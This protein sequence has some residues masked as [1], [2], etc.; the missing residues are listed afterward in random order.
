[1]KKLSL[2]LLLTLCCT[3]VANAATAVTLNY[4]GGTSSAPAT[5]EALFQ[6]LKTQFDMFYG[7]SNESA[8]IDEF[9]ANEANLAK[10]D[11]GRIILVEANTKTSIDGPWLW[12]ASYLRDA[13]ASGVG[14]K[15]NAQWWYTI[16]A[17]L[18]CKPKHNGTDADSDYY[19][20]TWTENGKPEKW[21]QWYDFYHAPNKA[22]YAFEGWYDG[23]TKVTAYSA[24]MPA[25]TAKWL[26]GVKVHAN[27]GTLPADIP[28]TT[29]QELFELFRSVY[30]SPTYTVSTN[31][32]YELIKGT[33]TKEDPP[34]GASEYPNGVAG[35][36]SDGKQLKAF[37]YNGGNVGG[38]NWL[39]EYLTAV[40]PGLLDLAED[41]ISVNWR[42]TLQAFFNK[43]TWA[44]GYVHYAAVNGKEYE[45]AG[46]EEY[47]MWAYVFSHRDVYT[48]TLTNYNFVGWYADPSGIGEPITTWAQ[49]KAAG[50]VYAVWRKNGI[51]YWDYQGGMPP[52][53]VLSKPRA[54]YDT[55]S[56]IN[57]ND[58]LWEVFMIDY[59]EYAG[60]T[61]GE[62]PVKTMDQAATFAYANDCYFKYP[63]FM[64]APTSAWKWLGDYI[65]QVYE[66]QKTQ[67]SGDAFSW[68]NT[69]AMHWRW[70]IAAFF[71]KETAVTNSNYTGHA[72]FSTAGEPSQWEY[73][74]K[75]NR[76]PIRYGYQFGGWYTQPNGG[77]TKITTST[78]LT[79]IPTVFAKWKANTTL[80]DDKDSLKC[81]S[82]YDIILPV[83]SIFY[84]KFA[85]TTAGTGDGEDITWA[86]TSST[87]SEVQI[88]QATKDA[89][90]NW[91]TDPYQVYLKGL[92]PG[93]GRINITDDGKTFSQDIWVAA[94]PN[95]D[96]E[97][98]ETATDK[99]IGLYAF[100]L[101]LKYREDEKKYYFQFATNAA[102]KGNAQLLNGEYA[103]RVM[104]ALKSEVDTHGWES[105]Y[106]DQKITKKY[107]IPISLNEID[108]KGHYEKSVSEETLRETFGTDADGNDIIPAGEGAFQP[109]QTITWAV[110]LGTTDVTE[111][112]VFRKGNIKEGG[113]KGVAISSSDPESP[114]FAQ[115]YGYFKGTNNLAKSF[116]PISLSATD[117]DGTDIFGDVARISIDREGNVY[118]TDKSAEKGGLYIGIVDVH[119]PER[120]PI[121][122]FFDFDNGYTRDN[123]DYDESKTTDKYTIIKDAKGK[124]VGSAFF[125][126]DTYV[127]ELDD[128]VEEN[129]VKVKK[130]RN[131]G[132]LFVYAKGHSL[133]YCQDKL[134][135][136]NKNV[137]PTIAEMKSLW[138]DQ[139]ILPYH[140]IIQYDLGVI[141]SE[142]GLA[143]KF[144]SEKTS[145]H[146]VLPLSGNH[147]GGH[148]ANIVATTKGMW[149][150][151]D[152]AKW[153]N[154]TYATSL[155]FYGPQ[156]CTYSSANDLIDKDG[157]AVFPAQDKEVSQ[158]IT[159]SDGG[160]FAVNRDNSL[161]VLQDG[162][163]NLLVF[164]I[165]WAIESHVMEAGKEA[166][167][168]EVP[169]LSLRNV[170][171]HN[172][173]EVNQMDFDYAGNLLV[174]GALGLSII[175]IPGIHEYNKHTTPASE[176]YIL[177]R[178]HQYDCI[179]LGT[180]GDGSWKNINNWMYEYYPDSTDDVRI[181][182]D[183][184]IDTVAMANRVYLQTVA[185]KVDESVVEKHH[186]TLTV[187]TGKSLSVAENIS[188]TT[189]DGKGDPLYL[190]GRENENRPLDNNT[191]I[192]LQPDASLAYN[193]LTG[194]PYAEV[195]IKGTALNSDDKGKRTWQYTAVPFP[196]ATAATNFYGSWLFA[197]DAENG[198]DAIRTTKPMHL[199]HGYL[200]TQNA[201]ITYPVI[202]KLALQPHD[203]Q[204]MPLNYSESGSN[205]AL[206]GNSWVTPIR[207]QD[208]ELENAEKSVF[209]Y[210]GNE[211]NYVSD[212][213]G[214]QYGQYD[215]WPIEQDGGGFSDKTIAPLGAFFVKTTGSGAKA[216]V[217]YY[218]PAVATQQA[219][220]TAPRRVAQE[221]LVQ[222]CIKLNVT[223][224]KAGEGDKLYL[225]ESDSYTYDFDNGYEATKMGGDAGTPYLAA[226][227]AVGDLAVLATPS[228]ENTMLNFRQGSST[229]YTFHF[230]YDGEEEYYLEDV[231]LN[232]FTRIETGA[233][234]SFSVTDDDSQ[235]FRIV[236]K[237][238]HGDVATEVVNVWMADNTLFMENPMNENVDIRIYGVDGKLVQGFS[239]TE[240]V[241]QL[242]VPITGVYTVQL[243]TKNTVQTIKCVL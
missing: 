99:Q 209:V 3:F 213:D 13:C 117:I 169:K 23:T 78:D 173:G 195:Q 116:E 146:A 239:T 181:D 185:V 16:A 67:L 223:S 28:V 33:Y 37:L 8:T 59:R 87:G 221:A 90:G 200:L 104:V 160:A 145:I 182:T 2:V 98:G 226:T 52:F 73:S 101:D 4:D 208:L 232:Q 63:D 14:G 27:G 180:D 55:I 20:G 199:F 149:I 243:R 49:A 218:N 197:W 22:G 237:P 227:T 192:T 112:V 233:T 139:G 121:H 79:N 137:E 190:Y 168:V 204:T 154:T 54:E 42:Y 127:K 110:Q 171:H 174:G 241:V 230:E 186:N 66:D 156:G 228:F 40:S 170:Y 212:T 43:D 34:T 135:I 109:T 191:L 46:K 184:I 175:T 140:C 108:A 150:G 242:D 38:W 177:S 111:Y 222:T 118:F 147:H 86:Y 217:K 122:S 152:R 187:Q 7:T 216:T 234:Y 214:K 18:Q 17:F 196:Q 88:I 30:K 220:R 203:N 57:T 93:R 26:R 144:D 131:H 81:V 103:G 129:G 162:G 31:T 124:E 96:P 159:G 25:L 172:L 74:F 166:V 50:N 9:F 206:L 115:A 97:P 10:L 178:I 62:V 83:D 41:N 70:A 24:T 51:T 80:S 142:E 89:N 155:Q 165:T 72:D 176:R 198:W 125:A 128:E 64:K 134:N 207:I 84:Y 120:M 179:F 225:F 123:S 229:Y 15:T 58:A 164:D 107:E 136:T 224:E 193:T 106:D 91:K 113:K 53:A 240:R 151:H 11:N 163:S 215:E 133:S 75:V 138:K 211:N 29:N 6:E 95:A 201:E 76:A 126:V 210:T 114:N 71:K 148:T 85:P 12:L 238:E 219:S 68:D 44:G 183:V 236:R 61:E 35:Y 158:F 105:F 60:Y 19:Y 47:W 119:H 45:T 194:D 5:N 141:G 153:N 189:L 100:H 36:V 82:M 69:S 161:L 94:Q 132:I 32:N 231:L 65:I 92:Q 202:D 21:R 143:T 102:A 1:M 48:P 188:W 205:R 157:N 130:K 39:Y 77:G 56:P 167:S 235:R